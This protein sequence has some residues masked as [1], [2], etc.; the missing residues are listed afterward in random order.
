ME[1]TARNGMD[2]V[3]CCVWSRLSIERQREGSYTR[4]LIERSPPRFTLCLIC[5]PHSVMMTRWETDCAADGVLICFDLNRSLS[6]RDSISIDIGIG[7][8]TLRLCPF[9][10]RQFLVWKC[11]RSTLYWN[12]MRSESVT[13]FECIVAPTVW[14]FD[15]SASANSWLDPLHYGSRSDFCERRAMVMVNGMLFTPYRFCV[16]LLPLSVFM[17][18]RESVD[19]LQMSMCPLVL[20]CAVT[21]CVGLL[22]LCYIIRSIPF[23]RLWSFL[24]PRIWM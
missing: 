13:C 24:C 14:M 7:I 21:E 16:E 10:F 17:R 3:C 12:E 23:F 11:N 9:P 15:C 4:K 20:R 6:L 1:W 8:I 19:A 5:G 2:S 22:C 18:C